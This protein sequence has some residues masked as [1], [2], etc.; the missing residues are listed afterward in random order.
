MCLKGV[1]RLLQSNTYNPSF[2]KPGLGCQAVHVISW[3]CSMGSSRH[4]FGPNNPR[5]NQTPRGLLL[6]PSSGGRHCCVSRQM[7]GTLAWQPA[8]LLSVKPLELLGRPVQLTAAR[9]ASDSLQVLLL[10]K[11]TMDLML[12]S[13]ATVTEWHGPEMAGKLADPNSLALLLLQMKALIAA[14]GHRIQYWLHIWLFFVLVAWLAV[15][16]RLPV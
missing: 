1:L 12:E 14:G 9:H 10:M 5:D 2:A 15:I 8:L 13:Q 7:A 3:V 11:R 16:C 4:G 6:T